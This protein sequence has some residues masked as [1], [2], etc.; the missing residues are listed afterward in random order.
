[1]LSSAIKIQR[2]SQ[3]INLWSGRLLYYEFNYK[4]KR[5]LNS[6]TNSRGGLYK[7]QS[8]KSNTCEKYVHN[9][10]KKLASTLRRMK[11][12]SVQSINLDND[13]HTNLIFASWY[14]VA[15]IYL[16]QWKEFLWHFSLERMF[17]ALNFRC[18]FL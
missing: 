15:K 11:T 16:G 13:A 18:C 5:I 8:S 12:L 1:M 7:V 10:N 4:T 17:I 6:H 14:Q 3:A 9:I 2:V